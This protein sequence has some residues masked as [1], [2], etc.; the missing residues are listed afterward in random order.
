VVDGATGGKVTSAG[1]GSPNKLLYSLLGTS[2]APPPPP[3]AGCG[4]AET[5]TGTLSGTNASAQQPS[6]SGYTT[7]TSG[8]HRGCLTGP[9][10]SDL[11]LALY[12][13]SASGAWTQV[14]VSQGPTSTENIA[15]SGTAGTYSW[16]VHSYRGGGA[17]VFGMTRP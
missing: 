6:A 10:S 13:R 8:T 4:L 7:T 2:P 15:Y 14:A 16:L 9:S 3:P 11:D 12:K 5:S 17:Y 1:A